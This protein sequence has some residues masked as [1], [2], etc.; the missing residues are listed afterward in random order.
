M[1]IR[2]LTRSALALILAALVAAPLVGCDDDS[3]PIISPISSTNNTPAPKR[4]S[5]LP[6][7]PL[8]SGSAPMLSGSFTDVTGP[9]K[10][11]L[12]TAKVIQTLAVFNHP[13]SC[14]VSADGKYLY[15]TNS[16]AIVNGITGPSFQYYQGAISKLAIDADGRLK[17]V[18]LKLV[19]GIHAPM[20][21]GILPKSTGKFRAGS[22]FVCTGTTAGLDEKGEHITDI[23]KF[24]P[25]VSI[26][27]PDTGKLLGFIAMGPDRAV[28]R[29]IRHTV[30]APCGLTF[31]Q[32]GNLYVADTGNTGRDLDP[33][34]NGRPGLLRIDN[35]NI[36]LYAD[37]KTSEKDGTS[38]AFVSERHQPTAVFYS[39]LDDGLY[40][41]TCDSKSSEVVGC[42]YRVVREDFARSLQQN[43]L[44]DRDGALA[45][46]TITPSGNLIASDLNGQ[47]KFI[48]KRVQ[49]E[50]EFNENG[51]FS[52]P[53]DLKIHTSYKGYN[54]LYVPEQEPNSEDAWKQRLRVVMLPKAL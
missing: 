11:D 47:L 31:D 48:G 46:L 24:N 19:E 34:I 27:D 32:Q 17:P 3:N 50:I 6:F 7:I 33:V 28:A 54:I 15:V 14:A 23:R 25:G 1:Q 18:N 41:T 12:S 36:D 30:L 29:S 22:L 13:Q 44:G 10:P 37:N 40:W 43:I 52:S 16:G 49:S 20:G 51:S 21:I 35:Q 42:V 8:D 9:V 53:A 4:A 45:G 39:S 38:V 26:Y 2:R 5:T